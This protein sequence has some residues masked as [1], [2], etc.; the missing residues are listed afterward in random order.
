MS[1]ICQK[2]TI[3]K[4]RKA[5]TQ[6][7]PDLGTAYNSV[8]DRVRS[9]GPDI[10]DVIFRG[11]AWILYASR[12]L[13]IHELQEALA[14]E[15]LSSERDEDNVWDVNQ[16]LENFCG[17]VVLRG[18]IVQFVHFTLQER[19]R[20]HHTL[21]P[22]STYIAKL[23]L[24]YATF[25]E[26]RGGP[27]GGVECDKFDRRIRNYP[28]L[29]YVAEHWAD[30]VKGSGEMD[31]EIMELVKTLLGSRK[32]LEVLLQVRYAVKRDKDWWIDDYPRNLTALHVIA[33][34]QSR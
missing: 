10:E 30:C 13:E 18:G 23:C 11:L 22:P 2:Q 28:L 1:H 9:K 6:L 31:P 21:L 15:L 7:P 25:D 29:K 4:M 12:P 24:T 34:T 26:F 3:S 33:T 5:L 32:K 16:L 8:L 19:L 27:I 14:T 20:L 17:L